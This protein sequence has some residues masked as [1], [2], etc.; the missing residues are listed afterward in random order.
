MDTTKNI[1]IPV[2]MYF[3]S[4]IYFYML[5]L[6]VHEGD[7]VVV[8]DPQVFLQETEVVSPEKVE[9]LDVNFLKDYKNAQKRFQLS[10]ANSMVEMT[11]MWVDQL[12]RD[13]TLFKEFNR[14][15]LEKYGL[16]L[17]IEFRGERPALTLI[18]NRQQQ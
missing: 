13:I 7:D 10:L 18:L 6:S 17:P 12:S 4:I 8:L 15:A 2:T 5:A 9:R 11:G 3:D 14:Y 16:N 1:S